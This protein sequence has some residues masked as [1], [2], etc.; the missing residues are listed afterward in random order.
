MIIERRNWTNFR[1]NGRRA[2]SGISFL[3]STFFSAA[4]SNPYPPHEVCESSHYQRCSHRRRSCKAPLS[5]AAGFVLSFFAASSQEIVPPAG[6]HLRNVLFRVERD[7]KPYNSNPQ[8]PMRHTSAA[9]WSHDDGRCE[10]NR[11]QSAGV[12]EHA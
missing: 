5:H 8:R 4:A 11:R 1:A 7:V 2:V 6:R 3:L 10:M 12:C 9:D